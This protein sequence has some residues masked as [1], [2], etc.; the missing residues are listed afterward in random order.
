METMNIF[1]K[2]SLVTDRIKTVPKN[3]TVGVG[4]AQYKAVSEKDILAVVKDAEKEFGIFS[5][6]SNRKVILDNEFKTTNSKGYEVTNRFVRVETTYRFVNMDKPEEFIEVIAYGDGLDTGDKAPG[7]AVTYSDKYALMKAYKIET[8]DEVD[9][10]PSDP[11]AGHDILK[12]K[13]R[14]E[15]T[16]TDKMAKGASLADIASKLGLDEKKFSGML[17]GYSKL[18]EFEQNLIKAVR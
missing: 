9:A 13:E 4:N 14:I 5:Y 3:I 8:G 11:L 12:V 2:M 17:Q 18:Y 6:P 1:Q 15:K 16:I 7:K 10:T